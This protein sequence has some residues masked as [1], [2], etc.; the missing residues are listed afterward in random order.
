MIT[1]AV[2]NY[3][4]SYVFQLLFVGT[5]DCQKGFY[6]NLSVFVSVFVSANHKKKKKKTIKKPKK[7]CKK[8]SEKETNFQVDT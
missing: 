7:W 1:M 8:P 5:H 2:F 3:Y 4:N 6:P